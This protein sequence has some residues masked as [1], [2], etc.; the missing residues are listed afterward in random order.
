MKHRLL[1]IA[2]K[3]IAASFLIIFFWLMAS[4]KNYGQ[5]TVTLTVASSNLQTASG[6]FTNTTF[7]PAQKIAGTQTINDTSVIT[8]HMPAA[9]DPDYA[10]KKAQWIMLYPEEYKKVSSPN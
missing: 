7:T 3:R 10:N 6:N 9:N 5:Q 1:F 2:K 8:P 4:E